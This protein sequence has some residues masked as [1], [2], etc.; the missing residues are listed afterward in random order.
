MITNLQIVFFF[1]CVVLCLALVFEGYSN[2]V[3]NFYI[4][5]RVILFNLWMS[6]I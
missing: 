4:L 5:V 1:V 6:P 3:L 2:L